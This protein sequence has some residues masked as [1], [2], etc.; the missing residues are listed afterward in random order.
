MVNVTPDQ[1]CG[2]THVSSANLPTVCARG[3][4]GYDDGRECS[5]TCGLVY[6]RSRRGALWAAIA[7]ERQCRSVV[8]TLWRGQTVVVR[9]VA[10]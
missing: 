1:A 5:L 3:R 6:D 8:A 9:A 2:N 4:S 10:S 7:L